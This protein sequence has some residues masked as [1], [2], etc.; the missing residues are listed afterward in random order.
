MPSYL[1]YAHSKC[2]NHGC[3]A[4]LRA[5][6]GILGANAQ[7]TITGGRCGENINYLPETENMRY[8]KGFHLGPLPL[9]AMRKA[10]EACLRFYGRVPLKK[11][12]F[13]QMMQAAQWA[14]CAISVGGDIHSYGRSEVYTY[15]DVLV[16]R[17]ARKSVLWGCS[18]N[19]EYIDEA[20]YKSKVNN[21]RAFSLVTARESLTYNALKKAGVQ[22][23]HLFPDPA[24]ALPQPRINP[25]SLLPQPVVGINASPLIEKAGAVPGLIFENYYNLVCFILRETPCNVLLVPH[26]VW[27]ESDD[28]TVLQRLYTRFAGNPRVAL[29]PDA[30]CA[31]LK[32]HI[33]NC[34]LFVGARTHA[35]IAAYANCVPTLAVGYSVKARGI[36]TDIFGTEK[37]YVADVQQ[38]KEPQCLADAFAWLYNNR[39]KVRLHLQRVMPGYI[40]RAWQAGDALH[41]LLR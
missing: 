20:K 1:L 38:L 29:L 21:L 31:I 12:Q 27:A 14:D 26:V 23:L 24:F 5:T 41:A 37:H 4:I 33:A 25:P 19:P 30:N 40:T 9:L 16:R 2:S 10:D 22:N 32:A 28:R 15:Q 39:Q 11:W 8:I 18:I 35:T 34:N 13:G 36:A 3:E 6:M 17:Y 7:Y